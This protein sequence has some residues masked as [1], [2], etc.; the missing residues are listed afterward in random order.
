[1]TGVSLGQQLA[2]SGE[3]LRM[4]DGFSAE[5]LYT[6]PKEQ[7]S[8]VTMTT[9]PKGRLIVSDQYGSLY[10]VDVAND[11][12]VEPLN[13]KLGSA[14]G[15]LCA[16]DSLYVVSSYGNNKKPP[17]LYRLKDTNGDDQYDE[18]KMLHEMNGGGEHGPHAVILSPDKKSIYVCAGNHTRLPKPDLS[19]VPRLWAEDQVIPRLPDAGGH[20]VGKMAPGGWICKSDPDGKNFELISCG[21]RNQYDIAFD[22]NGELFTWDADMEWDVGLPWYRPTRVCHATSGSEFGWRHGSGKWP[23]YFPDSLPSVV[24]VGPGSPTGI[25]FGYGAKF[26]AKYQDAL[27][28]SCLLYTSPSPRDQRGSRMPSSA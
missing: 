24:D 26:P 18:I 12:K 7:G 25:T 1:M 16:F 15:L 8:W 28:I 5:L 3:K 6:V 9:D 11:F 13:I 22:R 2:T 19:R 14:Q 23:S 20:A 17:G 4:P 10:R 21:Y 27:F